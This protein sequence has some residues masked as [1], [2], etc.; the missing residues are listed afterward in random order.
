MNEAKGNLEKRKATEKHVRNS[1]TAAEWPELVF[2]QKNL[3][4]L[5]QQLAID[6]VAWS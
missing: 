6:S 4:A 5:S 2:E 3:H 1:F